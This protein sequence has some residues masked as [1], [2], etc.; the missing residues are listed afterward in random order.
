MRVRKEEPGEA[1]TGRGFKYSSSYY[2]AG[3]LILHTSLENQENPL[4]AHNNMMICSIYIWGLSAENCQHKSRLR[5]HGIRPNPLPETFSSSYRTKSFSTYGGSPIS[6][7]ITPLHDVDFHLSFNSDPVTSSI[8]VA[9]A[10][11]SVGA[12]SRR[13]VCTIG[14]VASSSWVG[15][16]KKGKSRQFTAL[17]VSCRQYFTIARHV[18]LSWCSPIRLGVVEHGTPAPHPLMGRVRVDPDCRKDGRR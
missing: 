3:K 8:T 15:K 16:G 4:R 13:R 7:S 17:L 14:L 9:G 10:S 5:V 12:G 6:L 1:R 2:I 18:W 11:L